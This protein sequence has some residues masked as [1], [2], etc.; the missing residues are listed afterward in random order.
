MKVSI[1][2]PSFNQA[3]FIETTIKS[4]LAQ[5]YPHIEY[6]VVDGG[7][8]DETP[9]VIE[10]YRDR[11]DRII[12]EPDEGQSDAINKGFRLAT[13]ELLA[14]INSDDYYFP[15]AVSTAV[16][17]F[18]QEPALDL[19]YGDCVYTDEAGQFIKYFS[20]VRPFDKNI[21]L[22]RSNFIMQPTT[23]YRRDAA[24]NVGFLRKEL[25]YTMD[26]DFW[27]RLAKAGCRFRYLEDTLIAVNREYGT[28]KTIAGGGGR[29]REIMQINREH[30]TSTLPWAAISFRIG[31]ALRRRGMDQRNF[32]FY[33]AIRKL[34]R[35]LYREKQVHPYG[36]EAYGDKVEHK[37]RICLPW[38]GDIPHMVAIRLR[39]QGN[40]AASAQLACD[41]ADVEIAV[42]PGES[43]R[44]ELPVAAEQF[45]HVIDV[46]G[47]WQ[48]PADRSSSL[49]LE[50]VEVG[51]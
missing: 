44:V 31:D 40:S 39:K 4:V 17:A 34:K 16:R 27:C 28:T 41:D 37:F 10:R 20:E 26:W 35:T 47:S 33:R 2:T 18:E 8:T 50:V 1:V 32:A 13:G 36:I 14:W 46:R 19:V 51:T 24:E 38:Y 22:N 43:E 5:N 42:E 25:Q 9:A 7:S 6:I 30:G 15:N 12:C 21:L 29:Q 49:H 23:F 11:I 48:G 3:P 45:D